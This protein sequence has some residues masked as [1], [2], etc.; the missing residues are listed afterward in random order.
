MPEEI[1][2]GSDVAEISPPVTCSQ[3]LLGKFSRH[4]RETIKENQC[5]QP[6]NLTSRT[7]LGNLSMWTVF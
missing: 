6:E 5:R 4:H 3:V 1:Y 7:V 2:K